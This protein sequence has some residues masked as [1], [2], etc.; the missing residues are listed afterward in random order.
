VST[1]G[2]EGRA[3]RPPEGAQAV[4]PVTTTVRVGPTRVRVR[5]VGEGPPLLLIMGIGGNLDMWG[6]LISRLPGRRLV[7]FD[8]PGTGSSGLSWLPPTMGFDAAFVRLLLL[9]LG[10]SRVDVLGYSWGGVLA[11][12]L[13]VQHP[14][15]VR[16]LVLG[17]TTVGLGGA[18]PSPRVAARMLTPRRY[19]SRSY[20]MRVA[21]ELY[22]GRYRTD[23]HVV[24]SHATTRLGR[25]PGAIG[26]A[27]QLAALWGYSTLP[28][29]SRIRA[30][31]LI[32]AGTDDPVVPV[33]N[34]RLLARCIPGATLRLFEGAGHL[35]LVDSPEV[36]GPVI[37]Q[38]LD[39]P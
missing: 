2:T 3:P 39:A 17:A 12:H 22:G 10:L 32:V 33:A 13:A 16:R 26:Y 4:G 5:T 9:R 20:F 21:P 14:G 8:F 27:S 35:L 38:F 15:V 24:E 11:Q 23:P 34:P 19:T 25:P 28:A 36:V 30:R 1:S 7:M 18:P 37:E 29:L 6:P 31:T